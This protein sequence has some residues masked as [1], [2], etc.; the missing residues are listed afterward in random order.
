LPFI[1]KALYVKGIKNS[2]IYVGFVEGAAFIDQIEDSVFSFR[3]H[4]A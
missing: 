1:L 3:S 2:K 4:Q